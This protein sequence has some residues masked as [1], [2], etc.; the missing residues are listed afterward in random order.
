MVGDR[1]DLVVERGAL[2]T[3]RDE[4][5]PA[6]LPVDLVYMAKRFLPIKV[7]AFLDFAASG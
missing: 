4:F 7:R 2:T 3:L 6:P 1:C 5:Q